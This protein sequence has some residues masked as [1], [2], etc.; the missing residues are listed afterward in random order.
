MAHS[1]QRS[2]LQVMRTNRLIIRLSS[3]AL[4]LLFLGT[5]PSGAWAQASREPGRAR[6]EIDD[7]IARLTA[8]EARQSSRRE[9]DSVL[10]GALIGAG[11]AVSIGL[12]LCTRSEP[13]ENCR[14]DVGPMLRIGAIGAGIGIA[15]DA[16]IRRKVP[17]DTT[18]ASRVHAAPM[19]T[20]RAKGLQIAWTF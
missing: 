3:V 9:S 5:L 20:R 12:F 10:N 2:F 4:M 16:L 8:A 13:W 11:T 14:D 18:D 1:L 15:I 19:V 17:S 6:L 7:A